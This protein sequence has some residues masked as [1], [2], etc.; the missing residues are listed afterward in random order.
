[1]STDLLPAPVAPEATTTP[2]VP[3]R[4]RARPVLRA[5][6]NGVTYGILALVLFVAAVTIVVPRVEGAVPVTVVS[7][8]MEPT[9]PVGTLA[10]V[11]PVDPADIAIGDVVTYLPNPDDLTAVTHRV[12]EIRHEA[13]GTR[14]FVLQGDANSAPDPLVDEEQ[15]RGELWYSVPYLGYVNTAVNGERGVAVVVVAAGFFLW[16]GVLWWKAWRD[17]RRDPAQ[18]RS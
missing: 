2:E 10:V 6:W 9:L 7:S 1:M 14:S 17:R 3:A 13:D 8:S 4:R 15:V 12:T 11:R 16:A 5:V 18:P